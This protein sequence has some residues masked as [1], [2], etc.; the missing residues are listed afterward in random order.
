MHANEVEF[1]ELDLSTPDDPILAAEQ[2]AAEDALMRVRR[3]EHENTEKE[4]V[5]ATMSEDEMI[6]HGTETEL[7]LKEYVLSKR[8][9]E[10]GNDQG[11]VET[12]ER[13]KSQL[14]KEFNN[15]EA[16]LAAAVALYAG[17]LEVD[18]LERELDAIKL[19]NRL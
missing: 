13:L 8:A 16:D 4:P 9:I 5:G 14:I 18:E 1:W 11:C 17:V 19:S 2:E 7:R 3:L 12:H 15:S 10:S 6:I